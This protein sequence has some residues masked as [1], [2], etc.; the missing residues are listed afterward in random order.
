MNPNLRNA[1]HFCGLI[2]LSGLARAC[3]LETIAWGASEPLFEQTDLFVGGQDDINTYRIPSLICTSKGTVLAFCEARRD[4]NID[5]SPTHLVLKRSLGNT[6]QWNPPRR[7]G[8]IPEGR[9]RQ[10]NMTWQPMQ[11]LIACR[12]MEAYM[13]PVPVIDN[14][15]GTIYL[16][17]N[18]HA[19]FDARRDEFG[20]DTRVWLLVS[21]DDGASWSAPLGLTPSVGKKALG[22]GVGIQTRDGRLVI[23]TYEGIIFS[24]D[25]GKMWKAGGKTT[26]PIN[27]SQVVELRDGTLML[28]TRGAPNRTVVLSQDGGASWGAPWRDPALTDSEVYG[29]C[30]ASLIRYSRRDAGSDE[31]RLLFANP[32]DRKYR[33]DLTVRLSDD[34]GKTW[35][36]AKLIKKGPGAYSCMTV[37]P[38][39]TVGIIYETGENYGDIV[40]YYAKLSFVRFNLEWL[41]DREKP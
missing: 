11:T 5:G 9:S 26:G 33:F 4:N 31:D 7:R 21:R 23:P 18:Y 39:G 15:D 37:L 17:V 20:G 1:T 30:Q 27:E 28:N 25:H 3:V 34:E 36:V 16:L 2:L 24:E 40:E 35:P 8:P 12:G 6:N 10:R 32:A 13:N 41:T 38:D 14:S 19:Q 29:G 22:P